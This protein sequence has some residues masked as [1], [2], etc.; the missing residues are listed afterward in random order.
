MET[1][2][3]MRERHKREIAELQAKCPHQ[4]VSDWV[5]EYWAPA[6][7]TMFQVKVCQACGKVVG[8]RTKCRKC[9][10]IV[11]DYKAGIGT[12]SRPGGTYYCLDCFERTE[13][14][15]AS[16]EALQEKLID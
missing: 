3:E 7:S 14:E 2:K 4:E 9:G 10:K 5:Q 15:V 6:H 13:E 1:I 16:D 11:E 8:R 12:H